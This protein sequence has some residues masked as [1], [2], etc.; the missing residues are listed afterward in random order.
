[1]VSDLGTNAT[2]ERLA[3]SMRRRRMITIAGITFRSVFIVAF[4]FAALW[5]SLPV[6]TAISGIPRLPP[7]DFAR[8]V[9]GAAVCLGAIIRLFY[10]PKDD[11]A[12]LTWTYIGVACLIT[13]ALLA[14]IGLGIYRV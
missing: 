5:S 6:D 2:K 12:Y 14:V 8:V 13:L 11:H 9:V 4:A 10:L 3:P 7:A 1:M